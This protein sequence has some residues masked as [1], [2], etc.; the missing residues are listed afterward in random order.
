MTDE[1]IA[2]EEAEKKAQDEASVLWTRRLRAWKS[3]LGA[4]KTRASAEASLARVSDPHAV[5]AVW[6]VFGAGTAKDH[7]RAVTLFGQI[8]SPA[9]T[10]SLAVMAAFSPSSEARRH[11]TE[12]LAWRDPR[13]AAG[14]LVDL[15]LP[16][17]PP[18]TIKPIY[19]YRLQPV[20]AEGVGSPGYLFVE[21]RWFDWSA[22]YTVDEASE[23][24]AQMILGSVNRPV[25]AQRIDYEQRVQVQRNLQIKHFVAVIDEIM[26]AARTERDAKDTE[27][28]RTR[29]HNESV[30]TILSSLTKQNLGSRREAW[31]KWWIEEL[32]YAYAPPAPQP[33]EPA[34]GP[35]PQFVQSFHYSCFA[36]GTIVHTRI[37][38][39]AIETLD[40]GDQVLAQNV[41]TGS[42]GYAPIVT[43]IRNPPAQT[44]RITTSRGA[45]VATEIH[46]FWKAGR[47]WVMARN[48]VIGDRIRT[49]DGVTEVVAVRSTP[50]QPV[51]NLE[52][53]DQH[54]FFV[55]RGGLLVHDNSIVEPTP[56]PFDAPAILKASAD[57]SGG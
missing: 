1:Q 44:L 22:R 53:L 47:G 14:L 19:R 3:D 54:D 16:D 36:A 13:D 37:G 12:A 8:D 42:L 55:G 21:S 45:V 49:K 6:R 2:S 39:R 38:P 15:L 4:S 30:A 57:A 34:S 43:V 5:T 23:W 35:R 26:A 51:Y 20:G 28:A 41:T 50:A 31:R 10:R 17:A 11:A 56:R 25:T 18:E 27:A 32:G 33:D 24:F 40:S 52:V 7:I 48:L 29:N 9:S 46:R